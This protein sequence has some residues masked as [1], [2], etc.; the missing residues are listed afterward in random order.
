MA[1]LPSGAVALFLSLDHRQHA[2]I[3]VMSFAFLQDPIMFSGNL[4]ENVDPLRLYSDDAVKDALLQAGLGSKKLDDDVGISGAGWSVGEKQLVSA[5]MT[6]VYV[7]SCDS[8]SCRFA[9]L[10]FC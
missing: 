6:A 5:H 9:L 8:Y 7:G 1:F 2:C 3:V 4:R 10:V